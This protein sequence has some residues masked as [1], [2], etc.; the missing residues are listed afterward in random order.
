MKSH[1]EK[2]KYEVSLAIPV[3]NRQDTQRDHERQ[4]FTKTNSPFKLCTQQRMSQLQII[5][6]K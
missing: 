6:S 4:V 3:K 1:K 2:R 5:V